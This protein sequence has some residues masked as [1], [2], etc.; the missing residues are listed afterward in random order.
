MSVIHIKYMSILN[1]N[2]FSP[3]DLHVSCYKIKLYHYS[4]ICLKY[5]SFYGGGVWGLLIRD[6]LEEWSLY[7]VVYV[8][9]L[10]EPGFCCLLR[11]C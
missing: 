5:L 6:L 7:C 4:L 1:I 11:E 8:R 10:L 2:Y 3:C 9:L